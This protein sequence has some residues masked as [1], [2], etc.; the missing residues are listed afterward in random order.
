MAVEIFTWPQYPSKYNWTANKLKAFSHQIFERRE[1][2]EWNK[3][4]KKLVFMWPHP[5]TCANVCGRWKTLFPFFCFFW[6]RKQKDLRE[7]IIFICAFTNLCF[8]GD[9]FHTFRFVSTF[10]V[11]F[12]LSTFVTSLFLVHNFFRLRF[13]EK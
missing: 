4:P 3:F 6:K 7:R 11:S 5:K 2:V 13:N 1:T 9:N 8:V 10:I 12:F